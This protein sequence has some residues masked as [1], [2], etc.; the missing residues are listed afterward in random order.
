MVQR[1][2]NRLSYAFIRIRTNPDTS[3][4]FTA[5]VNRTDIHIPTDTDDVISNRGSRQTATSCLPG[6]WLQ[7]PRGLHHL[8]ENQNATVTVSAAIL[9]TDAHAT[10]KTEGSCRTTEHSTTHGRVVGAPR[11]ALGAGLK[12]WLHKQCCAQAPRAWALMP[13]D[14]HTQT[15]PALAEG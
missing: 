10:Q 12:V 9:E 5:H 15:K 6:S 4:P 14:D 1:C 2:P 11:G 3:F 8:T 7:D 13:A